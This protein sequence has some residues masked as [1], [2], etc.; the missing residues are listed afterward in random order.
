MRMF[1]TKTIL[2]SA[3]LPILMKYIYYII[4]AKNIIFGQIY[5]MI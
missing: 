5:I 4:R 1:F 2:N 3:V